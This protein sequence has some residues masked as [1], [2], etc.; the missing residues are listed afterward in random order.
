VTGGDL[1][2]TSAIRIKY[3]KYLFHQQSAHAIPMARA[4]YNTHFASPC[5]HHHSALHPAAVYFT[6]PDRF[7]VR[8]VKEIQFIDN[9]GAISALVNGWLREQARLCSIS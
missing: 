5:T 7:P 6:P 9:T 3:G 1:S 2:I 8:E 4:L